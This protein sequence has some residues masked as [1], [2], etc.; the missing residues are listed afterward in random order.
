[1]N[2]YSVLGVASLASTEE[3]TKHYKR[4][5]LKY[6]PDKT[7]HNPHLTEKFKDL[8]RA[9]EVLKND[10]LRHIYDVFGEAGLKKEEAP[11]PNPHFPLFLAFGAGLGPNLFSQIF[12]D[13][14]QMFENGPPCDFASMKKHVEPLAGK[15]EYT[16]GKD[17]HHTCQ[18]GLADLFYGKQIKLSLP[19]RSKCRGCDGNGGLEPKTCRVCLGSGQ[20]LITH[21]NQFSKLQQVGLCRP[22]RG[23]GLFVAPGQTCTD[24]S[25]AGYVRENKIIK[26]N[27]LPGSK[28]GD[29]IYLR[30]EADEGPYIIPGDVIIHICERPHEFL[31]RKNND[32][33]MEMEV[34][35]R[36]ALMGGEI[37][38]SDFVVEGDT[39][40]ITVDPSDGPIQP[41]VPKLVRGCGMPINPA[42]Q[43]GELEQNLNEV[44]FLRD[45]AF[46]LSKYSRG[47]LFI[48]FSVKM[49]EMG[50]L[51]MEDQQVL[52]R[53]LGGGMAAPVGNVTATGTLSTIDMGN[54]RRRT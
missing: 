13:I 50:E 21:T 49:P 2:Y 53:V 38:V 44:D 14:G 39:L 26:I 27:L 51:T 42:T 31:V 16:K 23:T 30:G 7:N 12:S 10:R 4:L 25:G 33:F 17:I 47:N 5:A 11:P 29:K 36:T 28:N 34:D 19:K 32:L 52:M 24:C 9:Y 8:N 40:A 41:G 46:D 3:I 35:L 18:V 1:M 6:H 20:V 15:R 22:C 43:G 37:Y 45:A 48:N 54:K